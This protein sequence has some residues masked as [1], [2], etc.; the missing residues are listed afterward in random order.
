MAKILIVDDDSTLAE[1]YQ[2][3]LAYDGH[4]VQ[5]A[6]NGEQGLER[7]K[8]FQPDLILMD[9]IMPR[10]NG[11]EAVNYLQTD[12]E[13]RNIPLILISQMDQSYVGQQSTNILIAP[14]F[15]SKQDHSPQTLANF[16]NQ[17]LHRQKEAD[18]ASSQP[19]SPR[20]D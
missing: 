19:I 4:E 20:S 5:I 2:E 15:I 12:L 11:L 9:I 14:A 1:M 10:M 7:A 17:F 13:T 8:I 18:Q 6:L 3:R 16:V